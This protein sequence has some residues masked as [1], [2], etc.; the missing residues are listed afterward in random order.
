MSR[1]EEGR[2]EK[3]EAATR[4]SLFPHSPALAPYPLTLSIP[5]PPPSSPPQG[6]RFGPRPVD[7]DILCFNGA[8]LRS[9]ALELPHPRWR[10]RDFVLAPVSELF[11]PHARVASHA[12]ASTSS[13][14]SASS[15]SASSLSG[16]A[17]AAAAAAAAA[18]S[19]SSIQHPPFLLG[20]FAASSS[21]SSS[22]S[23]P[24]PLSPEELPG[25]AAV[26]AFAAEA[27]GLWA[28]RRRELLASWRA[29]AAAAAGTAQGA[30]AAASAASSSPS[31]D[32]P[33]TLPAYRI[34]PLPTPPSSSTSPRGG[35][36]ATWAWQGRTHVMG[37][38]NITP[39]SFS[40]G[41]RLHTDNIISIGSSSGSGS[42][43]GGGERG[44]S[45]AAAV[46][47]ARDMVRN[48]ARLI[49]IGGQST[50]PGAA[51]LPWEQEAARVV[52]VIRALAA[53]PVLT[54]A[55]ALLSV[56]TFYGDVARAAVLAGA[57]VINDV[58]AGT[59]DPVMLPTAA[60]LN[61]PYI[62]MHMRGDPGTM[63]RKEN[64]AYAGGRVAAVAGAELAQRCA[65]AAAA[66]IEPW[67]M[68]LDPGLGFAKDFA[69]NVDLLRGLGE[70]RAGLS[71]LG[72]LG[73][74][75]APLLLGPS[76][77][78]FLGRITG[79]DAPEERDYATAAAAALGADLR[80]GGGAGIVRAHHV[81]A[82]SDALAVLDALYPKDPL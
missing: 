11:A 38:L 30:V 79:R 29:A 76:R 81:G 10:E 72:A 9:E 59:L 80:N 1:T 22:S 61:V 15:F 47:A 53:D 56:D 14:S 19:P 3:R 57:H 65:A 74:E 78:G 8:A 13:P 37:I 60:A 43:G 17:A 18:L 73:T 35:G 41:G 48:G 63:Q 21:S 20:G 28:A 31:S 16:D 39:D 27:A 4:P 55:G 32:P 46:Q 69:G 42:G 44:G 49:D 12:H 26:E 67:R 2:K 71:P 40:D 62:A 77:K 6:R 68:I 58:S 52:P 54:S 50:R 34:L 51:R 70:F 7:L 66:G 36:D 64:T 45:V 24:P 23:P 25:A 33:F 5:V 75:L 82:T